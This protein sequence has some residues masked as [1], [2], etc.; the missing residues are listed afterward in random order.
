VTQ[1]RVLV[2]IEVFQN[3]SRLVTREYIVCNLVLVGRFGNTDQVTHSVRDGVDVFA[4]A[5]EPLDAS[6]VGLE[7]DGFH[8]LDPH[9]F[10]SLDFVAGQFVQILNPG[11]LGEPVAED[12]QRRL[13]VRDRGVGHVG[14]F[15]FQVAVLR[16]VRRSCVHCRISTER[17]QRE[18]DSK[19]LPA[20][21]HPR[22]LRVRAERSEAQRPGVQIPASPLPP[23][24]LF[25]TISGV[26]AGSVSNSL[27]IRYDS[28]RKRCQLAVRLVQPSM[29]T[30]ST[31]TDCGVSVLVPQPPSKN[32]RT[33]RY[34]R[35]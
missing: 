9:L 31:I 5:D 25:L 28:F 4:E 7:G 2:L 27:R 6:H 10:E 32:G 26:L 35:T 14:G 16:F 20:G 29:P 8:L 30:S 1:T 22:V 17:A 23:N 12:I 33:F 34:I 11:V 24:R 13:V 19:W 3:R 15:V 21:W 18:R